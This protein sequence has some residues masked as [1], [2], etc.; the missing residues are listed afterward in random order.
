[1]Q[2]E[3]FRKDGV[4]HDHKTYELLARDFWTPPPRKS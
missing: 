1:V 4:W 2:I 3:E